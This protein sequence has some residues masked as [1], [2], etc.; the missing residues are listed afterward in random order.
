MNHESNIHEILASTKTIALVG[1]SNKPERDSHHVMEFLLSKGY[2]VIP[3]NPGLAGS[4][5]HGQTVVA[6]LAD[7][8]EPVDMVDIFRNTED[9]AKTI[10]EALALKD[11]L[12]LKT[13]WCQLGVVP[14]EAAQR[15]ENAGL[16]VVLD[17]CPAIEWR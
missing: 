15:A 6:S 13:L 9:A 16:T 1:A 7:I 17:K 5:I 3:V 11:V 2:R 14:F 4:T 8:H 12:Q 10:D